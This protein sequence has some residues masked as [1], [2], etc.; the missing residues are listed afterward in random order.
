MRVMISQPVTGTSAEEMAKA[1]AGVVSML[2]EQ[3]HEV[4]G[5]ETR[6]EYIPIGVNQDLWQLG[7]RLQ[8][9]AGA[10]AVYFMDGWEKDR[11]CR[12]EYEACRAYGIKIFPNEQIPLAKFA[13]HLAGSVYA[14]QTFNEIAKLGSATRIT[15]AQA[16]LYI[17]STGNVCLQEE[18]CATLTLNLNSN[19]C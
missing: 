8:A 16:I 5:E 2:N 11:G 17:N 19:Y 13:G 1:R 10:D 7:R 4:W 12:L 14:L 15:D 3:G 18:A 9:M 6:R